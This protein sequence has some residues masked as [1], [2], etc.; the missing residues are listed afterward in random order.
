MKFS[1]ALI[2]ILGIGVAVSASAAI[3][4]AD[5]L[6]GLPL[7]PATENRAHPGNNDPVDMPR[8]A[9]LQEQDASRILLRV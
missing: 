6:T 5:P 9:V 8:W 4:T 1:R 7:I 2:V 3:L